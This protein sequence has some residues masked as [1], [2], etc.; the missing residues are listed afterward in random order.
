MCVKSRDNQEINF[1]THLDPI[2][3]SVYFLFAYRLE[4]TALL[5]ADEF[6][7]QQALILA[8]GLE[9]IQCRNLNLINKYVPLCSSLSSL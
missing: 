2:L 5:L 4:S 8:E 1:Q 9:E 6:N 3:Y 7:P